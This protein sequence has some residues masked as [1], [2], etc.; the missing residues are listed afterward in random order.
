MR[1]FSFKTTENTHKYCI[2]VVECLKTY[3]G[4]SEEKAIQLV[5]RYWENE[6]TFEDDDFRLHEDPYYWAMCIAH[7]RIIGDNRPDWDKDPTLWPP[8]K[9]F[10]ERWY[11]SRANTLSGKPI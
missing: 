2:E 8:P 7:D 10:R 1:K 3:C 6:G 5:N 9:A 4:K 11:V